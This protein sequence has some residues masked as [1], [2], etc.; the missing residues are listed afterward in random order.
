MLDES[1][2]PEQPSRILSCG[3]GAGA[4]DLTKIHGMSWGQDMAR[5]KSGSIG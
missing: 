4:A 5:G 1:A 3:S 2:M